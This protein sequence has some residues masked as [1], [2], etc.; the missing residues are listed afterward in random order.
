MKKRIVIVGSSFA[1]YSAAITLAKLLSGKHEII[2]IDRKPEFIFLPSFVWYPFGDKSVDN[3]S[4]DARPIYKDLGIR[5]IQENIYGFDL[6]DQLI[7]LHDQE[8]HYDYLIIATGSRPRYE[9]IK[10]LYPGENSWSISDLENAIKTRSAWK[11]FLKNPGPIVIGAAQWAGYFFAAYEFLFNTVYQLDK[12]K[13]LGKIPLHFITPE[14]YLS[15]FGIGGF[16]SKP[17]DVEKFIRNLQINA[18]VNSEVHLV[19]PHE[20]ILE[21]GTHLETDFT[22]I[23]P[24]FIGV[25]AVRT[26]RKLADEFGLIK[27][28]EEFYHPQFPNV[29]AAGGAVSIPQ[30]NETTIGLDVPRTRSTSEIMAKS[31]ALNIASE[32]EGGSRVSIS[33]QKLYEY[34]RKDMQYL[35]HMIAESSTEGTKSLAYIANRA[36]ERWAEHSMKKYIESSITKDFLGI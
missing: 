35:D 13:L 36:Q 11:A 18:H 10:G 14:P 17:E 34:C 2:V 22:M 28:T 24:Q 3:I 7:Y 33:T 16:G 23:I 32:L 8:I 30:L 1:G 19:K 20:V 29:Y 9:S 27:V 21:D 31:A 6:S 26:T 4:F 15:H 5:F 25:D 12:N